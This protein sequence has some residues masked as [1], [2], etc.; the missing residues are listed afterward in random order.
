MNTPGDSR[1]DAATEL[2]EKAAG[3]GA[4]EPSELSVEV[5][6]EDER[7]R[8]LGDVE[9]LV[10]AA[11]QAVAR[12]CGAEGEACILLASD[13]DSRRLNAHYRDQDKP[14][15]VLSFPAAAPG[16]AGVLG[17]IAFA[18]ETVVREAKDLAIPPAAHLQHLVVHGLLHLLGHDHQHDAEAARM[19]H[20]E[21]E[22]LATIGVAN[23][24]SES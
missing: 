8:A 18:C 10:I 14:T 13:A 23:P 9:A 24:Y 22:I 4:P 12:H 5:I 3:D 6:V 1:S 7:W 15:N 20:L 16:H 19:E 11:A 2:I 17:D 21:A